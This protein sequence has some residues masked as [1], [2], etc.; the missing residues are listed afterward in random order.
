M[1]AAEN[2]W[3][4]FRRQSA[5]VQVGAWILV[6]YLVVVA[7]IL[8]S[9]L[10]AKTKLATIG[11][12]VAIGLVIAGVANLVAPNG[13]DRAISDN[14]PEASVA[15]NVTSAS[16]PETPV[17]TAACAQA[18]SIAAS[19]DTFN[20][21]AEDLDPALND[22]KSIEE[23]DL[24]A[25]EYPKA[26]DGVSPRTFLKNR[27]RFGVAALKET[28]L[29]EVRAGMRD[30]VFAAV[31]GTA[32]ET[33]PFFTGEVMNFI[34]LDEA[35]LRV[36]LRLKNSGNEADRGECTITAHDASRSMVGFD[37]FGSRKPVKPRGFLILR[38]TIRIEDEG[39]F[40]VR[41]VKVSDC[42]VSG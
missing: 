37:I 6:P 1:G 39:A 41:K 13:A 17:L 35:N 40:R 10:P 26:L 28:F 11:G 19:I 12:L 32:P 38:G 21:T 18:F 16:T 7:L 9:N 14:T 23:W 29:C 4:W 22:C 2:I 20:D 42:G 25:T 27:C 5:V 24:A 30:P 31:P 8:K 36:F 3:V 15:P 34:P 33:H